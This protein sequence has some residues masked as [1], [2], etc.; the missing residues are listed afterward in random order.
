MELLSYFDELMAWRAGHWDELFERL[1]STPKV[2]IHAR[3][4]LG[5]VFDEAED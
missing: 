2:I 5:L 3:K 1:P 4:G